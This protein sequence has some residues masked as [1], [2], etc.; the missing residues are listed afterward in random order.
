MY[1]LAWV[2]VFWLLFLAGLTAAC[3]RRNGRIWFQGVVFFEGGVPR[4][5][6]SEFDRL[7]WAALRETDVLLLLG[8]I[9]VLAL[10]ILVPVTLT[11][12]RIF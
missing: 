5:L 12:W 8:A 11:I 4:H 7:G 10:L 3:K 1:A 9:T 2:A 6:R